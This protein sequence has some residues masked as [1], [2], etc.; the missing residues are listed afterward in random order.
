[1]VLIIGCLV[2]GGGSFFLSYPS[3][4]SGRWSFIT[5]DAS[6]WG[7]R[8]LDVAALSK[9]DASYEDWRWIKACFKLL[10]VIQSLGNG[11]SV[12][13]ATASGTTSVRLEKLLED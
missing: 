10:P 7:F 4:V 11:S 8:A 6:R 5:Y 3:Q 13:G 2:G 1:V 12:G 9:L